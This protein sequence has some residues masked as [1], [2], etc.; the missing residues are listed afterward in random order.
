MMRCF[1]RS[2]IRTKAREDKLKEEI[3]KL[4]S[5]EFQK[6]QFVSFMGLFGYNCTERKESEK[7][8]SNEDD[9]DDEGRKRMR[10]IS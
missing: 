10:L 1:E 4:Q 7:K 2:E 6:S 8:D 5:E 9:R 3:I